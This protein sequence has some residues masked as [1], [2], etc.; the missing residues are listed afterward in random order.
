MKQL[1]VRGVSKSFDGKPVLDN[2][3]ITLNEGELVC[4]LG[5]SGGGKKTLFNIISGLLTQA[6]RY[7]SSFFSEYISLCRSVS[8]GA[9]F[10]NISSLRGPQKSLVSGGVAL[11]GYNF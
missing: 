2:I 5:I 8:H 6:S 3:S 1:E 4:L 9:I 10:F 7:N 11:C